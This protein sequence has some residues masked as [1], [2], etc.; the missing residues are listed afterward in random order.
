MRCGASNSSCVP[1][2]ASTACSA[3]AR[4]LPRAGRKPAQLNAPAAV[5]PA[6]LSAASALLA[7]GIGS[8]R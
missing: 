2:A 3:A 5:S 6:T 4:V 8:T 7:P 1:A